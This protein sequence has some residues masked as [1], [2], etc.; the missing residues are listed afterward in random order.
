MTKQD[1]EQLRA[2]KTEIRLLDEELHSLPMTTDSVTGSMPEHPYISHTIKIKGL[3][4]EL[5][6]SLQKR[7][8]R[9]LVVLQGRLKAM[10]DWLDTVEDSEMRT[11][12]RLHYR[13][14]LKHEVIAN[15]LGYSRH[16][17]TMKIKRFFEKE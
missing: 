17:I 12:L 4:M 16:A 7:L 14:G 6:D 11:I 15:E 2:L 1:L 9:K 5:H 13:N 10:E 8:E 3:D